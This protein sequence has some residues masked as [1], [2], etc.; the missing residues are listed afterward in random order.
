MKAILTMTMLLA[1][2]TGAQAAQILTTAP[3]FPGVGQSIQCRLQNISSIPQVVTIEA[4]SNSGTVQA[5]TTTSL[6][7]GLETF[8]SSAT[9]GSAVS[10]RFTVPSA[11]RIRAAATIPNGPGQATSVVTEAHR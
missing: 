3:I 2:A 6:G 4:I 1:L 9:D 11:K 7:G 10:C 5:G 8:V